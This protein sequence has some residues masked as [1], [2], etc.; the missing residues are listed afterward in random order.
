MDSISKIRSS[1]I[2]MGFVF[3][4]SV[5]LFGMPQAMAFEPLKGDLSK[6]DPNKLDLPTGDVVK[7]AMWEQ[8]ACSS[9]NP[10][11]PP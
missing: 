6:Y 9:H 7:I 1:L 3:A 10:A 8:A 11:D 5:F 2:F 4:F